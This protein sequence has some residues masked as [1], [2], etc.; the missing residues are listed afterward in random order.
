MRLARKQ[1]PLLASRR[2]QK[3]SVIAAV[4][5]ALTLALLRKL[6]AAI[7]VA[8]MDTIMPGATCRVAAGTTAV[9]ESVENMAGTP[10][11]AQ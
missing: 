5:F 9:L 6:V 10:T 1:I 3:S 8:T 2:G 11:G 7:N 4:Y